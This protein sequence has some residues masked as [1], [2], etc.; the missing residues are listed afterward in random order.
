MHLSVSLPAFVVA[1]LLISASPGPAMALIL[2]RTALHGMRTAVPLILGLEL[3]LYL[4]ALAAAAGFAAL[5]AAS[6]AAYWALKIVGACVLVYLGVRAWQAAWRERRTG[7]H[8]EAAAEADE[9]RGPGAVRAF[10]EGLVV[11][12]AN[13][14]AAV[15]MIAFYPQFVPASEPLFR[16]TAVLALLQVCIELCFYFTLAAFVARAGAWFRRSTVRG[17]LEAISGTVLVGLGL[18]VAASSR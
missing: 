4:W 3:G 2:R 7:A 6:E 13:P 10:A 8:T 14:K 18:R 12:L 11:Q 1:V 16:T 17:R 5:V 9:G 15:F